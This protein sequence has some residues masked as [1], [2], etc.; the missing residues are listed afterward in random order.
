[1]KNPY[2]AVN[3]FVDFCRDGF[4]GKLDP[5]RQFTAEELPALLDKLADDFFRQLTA[6]G[7]ERCK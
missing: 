3:D 1:M 2:F 7:K 4:F 6:K 5:N